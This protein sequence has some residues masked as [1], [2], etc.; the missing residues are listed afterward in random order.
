[1]GSE[2]D[3]GR[4]RGLCPQAALC[5]PSCA[6]SCPPTCPPRPLPIHSCPPSCPLCPP[7]CPP[8]PPLP[9][10]S[11]QLSTTDHPPVH[12]AVHSVHSPVHLVHPPVPPLFWGVTLLQRGQGREV[13]WL[14]AAPPTAPPPPHPRLLPLPHTRLGSTRVAQ[15]GAQP[16][17]QEVTLC[18]RCYGFSSVQF[19]CSV[20]S[21][22]LRPHESQHARPP[23]PSPSPGFH[24][25]SRPLSP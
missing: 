21:D 5:A 20:V 12:L 11:T 24:S 10:T 13:L 8:H 14:E 25:D 18:V 4:S 17:L 7:S 16:L 23:C 22:S 9:L 19:S 2:G 6:P 1:M 3:G 15:S